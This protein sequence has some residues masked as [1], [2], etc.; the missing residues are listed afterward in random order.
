MLGLGVIV[1]A[2]LVMLLVALT[3]ARSGSLRAL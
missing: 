2:A 3:V 1:S